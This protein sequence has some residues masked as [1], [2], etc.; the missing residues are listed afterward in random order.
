MTGDST[1]HYDLS[2]PVISLMAK[3]TPV[4][5]ASTRNTTENAIAEREHAP[6]IPSKDTSHTPLKSV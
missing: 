1:A 2:V 4:S 6:E 5:P 3:I